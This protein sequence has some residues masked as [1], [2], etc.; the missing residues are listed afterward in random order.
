MHISEEW[1]ILSGDIANDILHG[2][3]RI[4]DYMRQLGFE[5][6]DGAVSIGL[7]LS[8]APL[9]CALARSGPRGLYPED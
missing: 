4:A 8:D 1:Q 6:T 2:V 7:P 5:M 9:P 3:K